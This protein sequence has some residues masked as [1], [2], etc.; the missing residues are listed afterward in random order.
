MEAALSALWRMFVD[1]PHNGVLD[2]VEV[3]HYLRRTGHPFLGKKVLP[4]DVR[5][6][7]KLTV[8]D[9][10]SVFFSIPMEEEEEE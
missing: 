6:A 9:L 2:T 10:F 8:E 3:E 7:E 1:S 5:A 4:E